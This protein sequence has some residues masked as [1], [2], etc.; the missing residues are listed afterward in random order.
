MLRV[1]TFAKVF[2]AGL[3]GGLLAWWFFETVSPSTNAPPYLAVIMATLFA[4]S[5]WIRERRKSSSRNAT[6]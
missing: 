4:C 1:P 6:D 2:V 3:V 5:S